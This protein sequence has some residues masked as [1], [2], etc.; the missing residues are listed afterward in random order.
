MKLFSK[1]GLLAAAL[2]LTAPPRPALHLGPIPAPDPLPVWQRPRFRH[3]RRFSLAVRGV[4]TDLRRKMS[5]NRA[6]G[7]PP[8]ANRK[9]WQTLNRRPA[10]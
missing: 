7:I 4:L 8:G 1:L 2:G 10:W 3:A 5:K 6:R 9:A